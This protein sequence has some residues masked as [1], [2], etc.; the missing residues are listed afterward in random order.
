MDKV[1]IY[2]QPNSRGQDDFTNDLRNDAIDT[3]NRYIK[4]EVDPTLRHED[5]IKAMVDLANHLSAD[6][7][8]K[9]IVIAIRERI[10]MEKSVLLMQAD[11]MMV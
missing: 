6:D 9:Y 11:S 5:R 10:A 3:A 8:N 1:P 7:G 2:A 4:D